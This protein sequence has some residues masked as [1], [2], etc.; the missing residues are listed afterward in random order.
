MRRGQGLQALV[1]S[2]KISE[3]TRV[4]ISLLPASLLLPE[5]GSSLL[6][7]GQRTASG[8]WAL[9]TI[10]VA[11]EDKPVRLVLAIGVPHW[12]VRVPP[13]YLRLILGGSG[14]GVVVS[15]HHTLYDPCML[16]S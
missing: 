12:L 1:S 11:I 2:A 16:H 5:E 8:F 14:I 9:A 13:I 10:L 4:V 3:R 15:P 6:R 7:P